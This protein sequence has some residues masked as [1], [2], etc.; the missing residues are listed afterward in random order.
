MQVCV[1]QTV[2]EIFNYEVER[3]F[4]WEYIICSF[5][6]LFVILDLVLG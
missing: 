5:V 3:W 2:K 4:Y 1:G 6:V